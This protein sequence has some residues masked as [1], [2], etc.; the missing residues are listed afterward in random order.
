MRFIPLIMSSRSNHISAED[1]ESA[2]SLQI[3]MLALFK[4][5][6]NKLLLKPYPGIASEAKRSPTSPS[7]ILRGGLPSCRFTQD[8]RRP[9][10]SSG[11]HPSVRPTINSSAHRIS[12]EDH[13]FGRPS[14][15]S[16]RSNAPFDTKP[17]AS[18]FK[19]TAAARGG[20]Q[21]PDTASSAQDELVIV[22]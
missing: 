9:S 21:H 3:G 7:L 20:R 11:M 2:M 10:S 15:W 6:K 17:R 5:L 22:R 1:R 18:D 13:P 16:S 12:L 14:G 8:R 19:S 4:M